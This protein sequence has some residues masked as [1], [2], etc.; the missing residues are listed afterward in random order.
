MKKL[1]EELIK[2]EIIRIGEKDIEARKLE[3][4]EKEI[5]RRLRDTH[6]K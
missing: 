5:L 6:T 2:Q 1:K 4:R 3:K